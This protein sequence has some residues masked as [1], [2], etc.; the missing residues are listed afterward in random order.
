MTQKEPTP[1][2]E[3]M[4]KKELI[5]KKEPTQR[6]CALDAIAENSSRGFR[7]G[8]APIFVVR[9]N[10]TFHAYVNWCPHLCITLNYETDQFLNCSHDY[11]LC[12]NHGALFD[13]H[14]GQCLAGPCTGKYLLPVPCEAREDGLYIGDAPSIPL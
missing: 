3:L 11:I 8:N 6:L 14:T 4:P 2:K 13:I 1:K 9:Q 12:A 10:D 5:P 7:L